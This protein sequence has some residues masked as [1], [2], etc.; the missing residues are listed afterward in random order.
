MFTMENGRMRVGV[1]ARISTNDRDQNLD[2]QVQPLTEYVAAQ[3][4]TLAGT[5][6]DEASAV[7][8]KHRTGWKALLE[9][10]SK[11]KI[12]LILVHRLDRAFRSVSHAVTTLEQ[13]RRW[14]VGLRSFSESWLDTSG[15]NPVS[16]LILNILA[17]VAQF[18][19]SLI[20]SRVRAGMARA[21]RQG[22]SLGRPHKINGEWATVG[23][24]LASGYLSQVEAAKRL[25]V[26]R[27]TIWR[28]MQKGG[29][30][31][32]PPAHA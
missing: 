21:K 1:Y 18:E 16:D 5:W 19:R 30:N 13:L 28:M 31:R 20:A 7:D 25:H 9:A 15:E 12:D 29:R 22:I 24:L 10:A 2:T 27:S 32:T 11:R 6:T 8:L 14:R 3:G 26:S 17:S 4:W 23:P